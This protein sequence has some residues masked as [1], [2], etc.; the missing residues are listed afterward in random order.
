MSYLINKSIKPE[1]LKAELI[2]NSLELLILN[3]NYN[4]SNNNRNKNN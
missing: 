1:L 4:S 2:L 3:F